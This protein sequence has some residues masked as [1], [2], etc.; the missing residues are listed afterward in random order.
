MER[1]ICVQTHIG[2]L[3]TGQVRVNINAEKA[4]V[5]ITFD[6]DRPGVRIKGK[7][8]NKFIP[9]TNIQSVDFAEEKGEAKTVVSAK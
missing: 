9:Y 7:G 5:E 6:K 1:I 8:T 2:Q 3:V 4:G